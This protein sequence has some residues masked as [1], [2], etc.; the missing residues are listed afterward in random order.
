MSIPEKVGPVADAL[1]VIDG[2]SK[3][4]FQ[5]LLPQKKAA[6]EILQ[7][8]V[9]EPENPGENGSF[10]SASWDARVALKEASEDDQVLITGIHN[11]LITAF[12]SAGNFNPETMTYT[13]KDGAEKKL[14]PE[15]FLFALQAAA[16]EKS[17]QQS[18]TSEVY[19]FFVDHI[20]I[21][22][23]DQ[24]DGKWI[25]A[26][27]LQS[28]ALRNAISQYKVF[29]KEDFT[30]LPASEQILYLRKAAEA[31][32]F[33]FFAY[34]REAMPQPTQPSSE[35]KLSEE[36][37]KKYNEVNQEIDAYF[38]AKA[39]QF[40]HSA[41]REHNEEKKQKLISQAA[42]LLLGSEIISIQETD[43]PTVVKAKTAIKLLVLEQQDPEKYREF[44][45][46]YGIKDNPRE[47]IADLIEQ[48]LKTTQ[49]KGFEG[50]E[51]NIIINGLLSI[52]DFAGKSPAEIIKTLSDFQAKADSGQ[53]EAD[54]ADI[55]SLVSK[56]TNTRTLNS[57]NQALFGTFDGNKTANILEKK[58]REVFEKNG[59]NY[60]EKKWDGIKSLTN[61]L[62]TSAWENKWWLILFLGNFGLT[63]LIQTLMEDQKQ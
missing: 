1:Q 9:K 20:A 10:L 39:D 29:N 58:L 13:D 31:Y 49:G 6:A 46:K 61:K 33:K 50:E 8:M 45:E 36:E 34:E 40:A 2:S 23:K 4:A 44:I 32:E 37:L 12:G 17:S 27:Q 62:G 5:F 63:Q 57:I 21:K 15:Y 25:C 41:V 16:L 22:P 7:K 56:I 14:P 26:R 51:R 24:V 52:S 28:M 54:S 43:S 42:D 59:L 60:F 35:P 30:K 3:E 53:L 38:A 55:Y 47:W 18:Q 11:T 48:Q 19:N